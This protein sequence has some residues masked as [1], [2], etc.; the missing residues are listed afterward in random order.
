MGEVTAGRLELRG[1]PDDYA[2][3]LVR[4]LESFVMTD[5]ITGEKPQPKRAEHVMRLLLVR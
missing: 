1:D 2:Y 5:L 3:A 4:V